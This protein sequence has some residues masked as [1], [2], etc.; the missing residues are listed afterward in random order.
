VRRLDDCRD[1]DVALAHAREHAHAVEIGHHEVENEEIDRRPVDR[2]K[3][4][5]RAFARIH[6]FRIVTK[7]PRRRFEQS[8]LDGI[9]IGNEN[10]GGHRHPSGGLVRR[11]LRHP[12]TSR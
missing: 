8:A 7:P 11:A 10:E 4:R 3:T 1:R 6:G 12:L 2:L 5:Q 9:V